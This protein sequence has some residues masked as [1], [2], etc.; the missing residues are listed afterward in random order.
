MV[1]PIMVQINFSIKTM[2]RREQTA[3]CQIDTETLHSLAVF[4]EQISN[5]KQEVNNK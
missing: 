2:G 5:S 3:E 1:Y 4:F